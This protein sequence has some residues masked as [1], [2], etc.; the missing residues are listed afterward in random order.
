MEN[1]GMR[2]WLW[3]I[4]CK[5]GLRKIDVSAQKKNKLGCKVCK[6]YPLWNC[7]FFKRKKLHT[8]GVIAW[9]EAEKVFVVP[10]RTRKSSETGARR[11]SV[12][13]LKIT[14]RGLE[15]KDEPSE[16]TAG[17]KS[18]MGKRSWSSRQA[19]LERRVATLSFSWVTNYSW[20][21]QC[22]VP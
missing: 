7:E 6:V 11:C 1:R 3:L 5:R 10:A 8:L 17:A 16:R 18:Q 21:F 13:L 4:I 15:G 22:F 12:N 9:L 14:V 2:E 19:A 20:K